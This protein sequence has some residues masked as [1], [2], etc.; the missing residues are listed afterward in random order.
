MHN[1]QLPSCNFILQYWNATLASIAQERA[2]QCNYDHYSNYRQPLGSSRGLAVENQG[3][4]TEHHVS[5]IIRSWFQEGE[6]YNYHAKACYPDQYSSYTC[7][8]YIRVS[9]M[10]VSA[11]NYNIRY[12]QCCFYPC[13]WFGPKHVK[14][15]V[16]LQSV[17][18]CT[19]TTTDSMATTTTTLITT[20]VPCIF[21]S[22]STELATLRTTRTC[23]TSI[24]PTGLDNLATTVLDNIL[25]VTLTP[26]SLIIT[27][28]RVHK[29]LRIPYLVDFVVRIAA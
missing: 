14:L 17:Q 15:V 24:I 9:F 28:F 6:S 27:R 12:M 1:M 16:L 4:A 22:A 20:R 26:S 8:H 19:S 10:G 11:C 7:Q 3:L 13:R 23:S 29:M 2:C 18:D 25:S 21:W 5:D